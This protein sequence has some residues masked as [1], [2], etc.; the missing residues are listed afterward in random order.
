VADDFKEN[1]KMKFDETFGLDRLPM[2]TNCIQDL[3]KDGHSKTAEA[4]K[5]LLKEEI[6]GAKLSSKR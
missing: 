4:L 1:I 6:S 2:F 3:E 5:T